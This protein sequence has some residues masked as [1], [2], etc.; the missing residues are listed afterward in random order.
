MSHPCLARRPT[1]ISNSRNNSI[2][3][4]V[5]LWVGNIICLKNNI[6]PNI[7]DTYI[8]KIDNQVAR[9]GVWAVL[10]RRRQGRQTT[11]LSE[12]HGREGRF[13]LIVQTVARR[14]TCSSITQHCL[15]LEGESYHTR[16]VSL[17]DTHSHHKNLPNISTTILAKTLT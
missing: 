5:I 7:L 13:S 3:E 12:G 8:P 14:C 15:Q 1:H 6:T 10:N 9:F 11:N 17:Q 2:I 16:I 4:R